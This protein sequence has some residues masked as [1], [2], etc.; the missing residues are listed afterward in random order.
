MVE[1]EVVR[2]RGRIEVLVTDGTEI[3]RAIWIERKP[4][5]L[6]WGWCS[7]GEI[8]HASYHE[9]G[10]LFW[11]VGGKTQPISTGSRL[12]EFT[13]IRPLV[14]IGVASMLKM[15][16]L[17]YKLRKLDSVVYIDLRTFGEDGINLDLMLLEPG[18]LELLDPLLK[19]WWAGSHLHVFTSIEPW[20]VV[21]YR[22][23]A[24]VARQANSQ[25]STKEQQN[26]VGATVPSILR[27]ASSSA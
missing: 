11:K 4:N 5:G 26:W 1:K 16:T 7:T 10:R 23:Q 2:L 12:S 21:A 24:M 22:S 15:P 25:G 19:G 14:N 20:V 18:K 3:R 27:S 8:F 6:Y 17:P 9:D 13:G